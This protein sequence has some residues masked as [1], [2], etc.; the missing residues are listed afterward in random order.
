MKKTTFL[1]FLLISFSVNFIH[2]QVITVDC[3][4][5]AVNTDFCYF[6]DID[7]DPS[8]ATFIYTSS[9]GGPLNLNFNQGQLEGC[10]DELVVIDTNGDELFNENLADASGLSFQSSGDTISWYINSDFSV[11]CES[12]DY[13]PFDVS[14]TC[15]SCVNPIVSNTVRQDC[16]NGP[17]F[18]VDVNVTDLGSA[19]SLII[20]DNQGSAA[21]TVTEPGLVSFGPFDNE[22]EIIITAVNA[23][24]ANCTSISGPLTQNFCLE[25]IVDCDEGPVNTNF[26]YFNDI[27]DDPSVATFTY[28]S[29]DGQPLNLN[30]NQ[31]QLEGCCDE[32]VVLDSNGD[33]LFNENLTDVAGLTFQSSG[34]TIS[35][36]VNSDFSIGCESS[37][38]TPFDVSVSCASCQNPV[39]TYAVRED[40]ANGPQFFVDVNITDLGSAGSLTVSDNQDSDD[41][42]VTEIGTVSFGPFENGTDIFIT[43]VND[44]DPNCVVSSNALT[45]NFCLVS[46]VDCEEGPVNTNFCYFNDIDDDPSVATFTYT[47]SDGQ[48]LNLI[49]NEGQLE[50]CCDELVVIDSNGDELFNENLTNVAGLTFQSSGESISWY[51]NSDFSASCENNGYTPFDVTV[52][53]ATCINPVATYQVVDDCDSGEQFLIDVN[54]TSLG[55]ATSLTISNN[56][57]ALTVTATDIGTYQIG[58]FPFLTDVV[59]TISNDQ[60]ANCVINSSAIQLLACPPENDNPCNAIVA[61]VNSDENCTLLTQGTLIEATPSGV[62]DGTC[63]GDPDDDVWF[64][65]VAESEI[66]LISLINN[67][68]TFNLDHALYEGACDGLVELACTDGTA[69]IAENLVIGETYFVRVFSGGSDSETNTFDLCIRAAPTNIICDNAENFCIGEG[70]ALVNSNIIGIPSTGP[71][72]CLTTAPNPTWNIIQIG[73]DGLIE[74]Q[75]DQVDDE[76]IG[77]DV[78]YALWGPFESLEL[79]CGNLDLGCPEPS[80]CPGIPYTPEFYPFGN[81]AD[82]SWSAASTE[83][84]TID[85]AIAGEIYILLV[86]NFSD[87]PGSITIEQTN[88]GEDT[89]GEITAEIEVDLGE[90]QEFCGFPNFEIIATSPFADR[91]EWYADGFEIL[92]ETESTLTVTE[93]NVYTVIAFD[94]QCGVSA[95]AS[96]TLTFGQEAVA[97]AVDDMITCDTAPIDN[98]EQF[99]LDTQTAT[100]LGAQ[101]PEAFNVS[102]HPTL[103]D[104]Q[105]NENVLVSPYSNISN[106]QTIFVRVEDANATFCFAT[107][108]FDLIISGPTPIANSVSIEACDNTSGT[109]D[110]DLALHDGNILGDQ[111]PEEFTVTYYETEATAIEGTDTINTALLF[112]SD[113]QTIYARVESNVSSTCFS[114]TPFDLIVL[115]LPSTSFSEDFDYEVCPDATV[116][117]LITAT[118]NNYSAEEVSITWY[119]DGG[120]LEGEDNLTLAILE[121]GFYEIEVT[122]NNSQMCM[123]EP[124]GQEVVELESCFIPQGISPNGDMTNDTFDL[125]SFKVSSL[126]IFNRYGTS[127]YTKA[128]YVDEWVGQTNEGEELP[129][130]TYFY[131]VLFEDGE[132]QTGWVYIQRPN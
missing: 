108:S 106:P 33:E 73:S 28:T 15:A 55:D 74:I 82:C 131:S 22:T 104:A 26:C 129:V 7:D 107:T 120:V 43:A 124:V 75:I 30:F 109:A 83:T 105:I 123:A 122:F 38:Y 100:I 77:L 63:D 19:S 32:L 48:P 114:T 21:E 58:P 118:P 49:F 90:D 78:D 79:A 1:L 16:T 95:Q 113:S 59:V 5:G 20:N 51:I 12:N 68:G 72:A 132:R 93:T 41:I 117:I 56:I 29:S 6:N 76:G 127:V 42:V 70:G 99:D 3:D 39:V 53:C 97:N 88:G 65:F 25:A 111:S 62:S 24:D 60:D 34:D 80:D 27:D 50:G 121:E 101:D 18:F 10:C 57:D 66:H 102:Y 119:K 103:L 130:G 84:L 31:G 40:C 98:T 85:N 71:I 36:Y 2:G 87:D 47:S 126:E 92:G 94:D 17:Q 110:F 86:T 125:S 35:W 14:V 81:I 112:N 9:N 52:A 54:V 4:G 44:D 116:P 37:G 61:T 128:N 91:Y 45:Q 23:D 96:V 46:I 8:V 69:S 11:S 89:D 67:T 115:P 13:T 64:Q